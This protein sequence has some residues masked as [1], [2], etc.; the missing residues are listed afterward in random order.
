ML[1]DHQVA[2]LGATGRQHCVSGIVIGLFT[3]STHAVVAQVG[4]L[5]FDEL[6]LVGMGVV[7]QQVE[8]G[9]QLQRQLLAAEQGGAIRDGGDGYQNS[10][11]RAH[12]NL[13][14]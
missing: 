7:H 9:A 2:F 11:Y 13:R 12:G 6:A 5:P 10:L 14:L 1:L 3:A 4:D 8:F